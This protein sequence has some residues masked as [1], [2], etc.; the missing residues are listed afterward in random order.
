MIETET[1]LKSTKKD[2]VIN[3]RIIQ[4]NWFVSITNGIK[5]NSIIIF[6]EQITTVK[7]NKTLA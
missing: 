1:G 7:C 5:Q 4:L 3:M 2:G 6:L